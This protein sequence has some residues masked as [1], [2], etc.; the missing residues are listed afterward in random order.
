MKKS[1][2]K[3]LEEKLLIA[4]NKVLQVNK[5]GL[6]N[7][8]E[9]ALEKSFKKIVKKI[10]KKRAPFPQ[11]NKETGLNADKMKTHANATDGKITRRV[12][13]KTVLQKN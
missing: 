5:I 13:S 3:T 10:A 7:K 9:N 6:T 8:T 12:Q 1:E 11:K 4:T 2:R